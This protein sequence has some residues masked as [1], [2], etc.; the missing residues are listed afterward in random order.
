MCINVGI[1]QCVFDG[2]S[3]AD[4][5]AIIGRCLDLHPAL[6]LINELGDD[7]TGLSP[8]GLVLE[9]LQ[10]HTDPKQDNDS[11]NGYTSGCGYTAH[12]AG[13]YA[14][15]ARKCQAT[16]SELKLLGLEGCG[17]RQALACRANV[18]PTAGGEAV[19]INVVLAHYSHGPTGSI[20]AQK[21]LYAQRCANLATSHLQGWDAVLLAG[22]FG[23]EKNPFHE[24][25]EWA[26]ED[27]SDLKTAAASEGFSDQWA[28]YN[29]A[30][31]TDFLCVA[32]TLERKNVAMFCEANEDYF[33]KAASPTCGWLGRKLVGTATRSQPLALL[34]Q[35]AQPS[36]ATLPLAR[37]W[38]LAQPF[39]S[40]APQQDRPQTQE[41]RLPEPWR[42]PQSIDSPQQQRQQETSLQLGPR[43]SQPPRSHES[44]LLSHE[45]PSPVISSLPPSGSPTQPSALDSRP[46]LPPAPAR[47]TP[48]PSCSQLVNSEVEPSSASPALPHP[49]AP[50]RQETSHTGAAAIQLMAAVASREAR[51]AAAQLALLAEKQAKPAQALA[52]VSGQS[53]QRPSS[54][55]AASVAAVAT[56]AGLSQAEPFL[57]VRRTSPTQSSIQA[58]VAIR[59]GVREVFA[60]DDTKAI[61]VRGEVT[62]TAGRGMLH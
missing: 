41:Q 37:P 57:Q 32:G 34:P 27:D 48:P 33:A 44:P 43:P 17:C 30:L 36:L 16:I 46:P 29:T 49:P 58:V 18:T 28:I 2:E 6:L 26:A 54:C 25:L 52:E 60:T 24:A 50:P 3:W 62:G 1:S 40:K 10:Q 38:S 51:E 9:R 21:Q 61:A 55:R 22:E 53:Q 15:L 14:I 4:H 7:E 23:L 35:V 5:W 47:K 45:S 12:L 19:K 20:Q 42:Q 31:R 56:R 39:P 59:S 8:Q 13:G 11:C